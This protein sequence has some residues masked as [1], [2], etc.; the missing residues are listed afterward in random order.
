MGKD[1][2]GQYIGPASQIESLLQ[3]TRACRVLLTNP[4]AGQVFDFFA[5]HGIPHVTLPT[6]LGFHPTERTRLSERNGT[7]ELHCYSAVTAPS[8]QLA[9]R[10]L[11]IGLILLFSPIL[12][13][14]FAVLAILVRMSSP[15]RSSSVHEELVSVAKHSGMEVSQH[16]DQRPRSARASL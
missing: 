14:V 13:P 15:G 16:G 8:A 5:Y 6:E 12:V 4:A 10:L 11:D 2:G 3:Q 7:I 9:K 1:D